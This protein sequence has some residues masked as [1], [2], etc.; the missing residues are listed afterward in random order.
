[1]TPT[2]R[3]ILDQ[4]ENTIFYPY[5]FCEEL[6]D[7]EQELLNII[8]ELKANKEIEEAKLHP[9]PI[10][11]LSKYSITEVDP[12]LKNNLMAF[13]LDCG[14]GWHPLIKELLDRL[15][16]LV[17]SVSPDLN[18]FRIVQIKEKWGTLR[19]YTNFST[20]EIENI[21]DEYEQ[22]ALTICEMCGK[23]GYLREDLAW[24]QTLCDFHY[25][26]AK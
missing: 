14:E 23:P 11:N 20:Y 7:R 12:T 9:T 3:E 2:V 19:I 1:M 10:V 6:L 21:I 22:K 5:A 26:E 25:K 8:E 24:I 13:G 4:F 17:N 18:N 16:S 15:Q